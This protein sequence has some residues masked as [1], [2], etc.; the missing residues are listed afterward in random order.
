MTFIVENENLLISK[1]NI[2]KE[3]KLLSEQFNIVT[4]ENYYYELKR[5]QEKNEEKKFK[6]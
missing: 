5:T 6:I 3:I 1:N 2:L 4:K